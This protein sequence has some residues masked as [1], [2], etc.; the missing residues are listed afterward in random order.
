MSWF[1]AVRSRHLP[2]LHIVEV[3]GESLIDE[4]GVARHVTHRLCAPDATVQV[5]SQVVLRLPRPDIGALIGGGS[6]CR[7][8]ARAWETAQAAET[9]PAGQVG[10]SLLDLLGQGAGS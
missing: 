6:V 4:R 5:S 7:T 3:A 9:A 8:C 10:G 1:V 2:V